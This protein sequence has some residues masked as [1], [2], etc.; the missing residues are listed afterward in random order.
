MTRTSLFKQ[1]V[2]PM[3]LIVCLLTTIII[4]GVGLTFTGSYQRQIQ[5][6]NMDTATSIARHVQAFTDTAYKISEE[7]AA[8]ELIL[9]MKT[10]I[11]TPILQS[12]LARNDYIE[13]LYIQGMDGM[14]TGRSTGELANRKNRWWFTQM[15]ENGEPFISKSYY[16][17]NT[18]MP[19]ASIFLPLIRDGE[20]IGVFATDIKLTSLQ[21]L[22]LAYSQPENGRYSFIIDGD[23]VVVA[24]PDNTYLEELYNYKLMTHT[25]SAKDG[26]GQ[27]L[28][29][30]EGNI[31]T[32]EQPFTVSD[33]FKAAIDD[34]MNHNSDSAIITD[35]GQKLYISYTPVELSGH[36]DSWSVITVQTA[37]S[38]MALRNRILLMSLLAG[39][40]SLLITV[41]LIT[42]IARNITHPIKDMAVLMTQ[43]CD[44]DFT[45]MADESNRTELGTLAKNFNLL[46]QKFSSILG[47][48]TNVT[49]D[50]V[51]SHMVLQNIMES[52]NS[53]S[54]QMNMIYFGADEQSKDAKQ[55]FEFAVNMQTQF[56][57][58]G[59]YTD[60]LNSSAE[61]SIQMGNQGQDQIRQLRNQSVT[62]LDNINQM[63]QK[64]QALEAKSLNIREIVSTISDIADQTALLSLNASIE[65]ARAGEQGRGFAVVANEIGNLASH[66][67]DATQ[68]ITE[69]IESIVYEINQTVT[70]IYGIRDIFNQQDEYVSDMKHAFD[71]MNQSTKD[72]SDGIQHISSEMDEM[73]QLSRTLLDAARNI[74]DISD[75]TSQLTQEASASLQGQREQISSFYEKIQLLAESSSQLNMKMSKFKR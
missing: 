14:Q 58:V 38:A 37:S 43:V 33:S 60:S 15:E 6:Q 42:F 32:E 1:L 4:V 5:S 46:I 66:S 18:N 47:D 44:G 64:I 63:V 53:I 51:G 34:V 19:C 27:T 28:Y 29:D 70:G 23:G 68:N 24:H 65:A 26:A 59:A 56:E 17:V 50:I 75:T 72:M 40:V 55:V 13:L 31:V 69:I 20:M 36:S 12:T 52:S 39:I 74:S 61:H 25:V 45:I 54:E 22:V 16:S 41:I 35:N 67:A 11:Q 2:F 9:T 71:N 57:D 8:N 3:I 7:L 49:N 30:A 62:S 21:D 48:S 10:D 73:Y